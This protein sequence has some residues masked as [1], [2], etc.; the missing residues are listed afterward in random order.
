M[1]QF[2][3]RATTVLELNMVYGIKRAIKTTALIKIPSSAAVC[4]EKLKSSPF[5]CAAVK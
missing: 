2:E 3:T 1:S 4:C 5:N